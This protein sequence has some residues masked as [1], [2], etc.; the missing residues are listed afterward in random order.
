[1]TEKKAIPSFESLTEDM[2]RIRVSEFFNPHAQIDPLIGG[3]T[4]NVRKEQEKILTQKNRVFVWF[5]SKKKL[6]KMFL[7]EC[8][9]FEWYV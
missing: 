7:F 9:V 4:V 2:T 3:T 5:S 1:M 8:T 6:E